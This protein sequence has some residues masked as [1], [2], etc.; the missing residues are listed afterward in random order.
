MSFAGAAPEAITMLVLLIAVP[1]LVVIWMG[2]V[3]APAGTGKV[4]RLAETV[5]VLMGTPA[6]V[7]VRLAI[8][9]PKKL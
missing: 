5:N 9:L 3:V 8:L 2:P 4:A 1:W 6:T 7:I